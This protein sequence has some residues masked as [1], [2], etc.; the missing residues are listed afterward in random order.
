LRLGSKNEDRD[1]FKSNLN[2][3]KAHDLLLRLK[4]WH[5]LVIECVDGNCGSWSLPV[6]DLFT[7]KFRDS[8]ILQLI[9]W[10]I[11]SSNHVCMT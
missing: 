1:R 9:Q 5:I 7:V 2:L 3:L 8:L 6:V 4:R 11:H 10:Y